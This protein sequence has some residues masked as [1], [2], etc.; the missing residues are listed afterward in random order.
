MSINISR[1]L[2]LQFTNASFYLHQQT[3]CP[4][5]EFSCDT[6]RCIRN[7]Q[8]CD[9]ILDCDDGTDELGCLEPEDSTTDSSIKGEWEFEHYF[10]PYT[11]HIE[12]DEKS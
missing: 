11:F 8:R 1:E 7:S 2:L 10:L 3:E 4:A 12:Q 9:Q 5:G 6:T